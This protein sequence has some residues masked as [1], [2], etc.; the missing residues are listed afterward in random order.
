MPIMADR[1]LTTP[2]QAARFVSLIPITHSEADEQ[3]EV[4]GNPDV[5]LA[6]RQ[7]NV[8]EHSLLLCNLLLGFGMDAYV[9][10]GTNSE[11]NHSWVLTINDGKKFTVWESLTG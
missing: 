8:A 3:F 5:F 2:L 9:C 1:V 11:G 6:K 10:L 7:G 4:W